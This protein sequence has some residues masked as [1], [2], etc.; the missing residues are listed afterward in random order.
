MHTVLFPLTHTHFMY[1]YHVYPHSLLSSFFL[2]FPLKMLVKIVL[3][4]PRAVVNLYILFF[5][6]HQGIL[7]S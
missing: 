2:F 7:Y 4:L 6:F 3:S 5:S 1:L